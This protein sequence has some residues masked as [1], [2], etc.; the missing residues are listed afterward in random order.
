MKNVFVK[1]MWKMEIR[2]LE[3]DFDREILKINGKE[4]KDVPVIVTLP[5]SENYNFQKL[6]NSELFPKKCDVLNVHYH[7]NQS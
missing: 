1:R 4:V 5:G 6:F 2:K 3:I 7:D